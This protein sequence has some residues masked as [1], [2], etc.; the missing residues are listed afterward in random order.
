MLAQIVTLFR[1]APVLPDRCPACRDTSGQI[2]A[3]GGGWYH[4]DSCAKDF[5]GSVDESGD[6]VFDVRSQR[7]RL[8]QAKLAV[9]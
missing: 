8:R 2:A 6:W 4:C 7:E 1:R 9:R 3:S 5:T